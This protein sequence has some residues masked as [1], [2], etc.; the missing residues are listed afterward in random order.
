[1]LNFWSGHNASLFFGCLH[2]TVNVLSC[3][4]ANLF[5]AKYSKFG[6]TCFDIAQ[7]IILKHSRKLLLF[8]IFDLER[9]HLDF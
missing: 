8:D 9:T 3:M 5:P 6:V 2:F 4:T 1:M 7:I